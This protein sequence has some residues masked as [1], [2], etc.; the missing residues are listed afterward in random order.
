M[1]SDLDAPRPEHRRI[2]TGRPS[3]LALTPVPLGLPAT[4]SF[5]VIET[6]PNR[7]RSAS[8][9]ET[10]RGAGSHTP[11]SNQ[12]DSPGPS[13]S[14]DEALHRFF[15]RRINARSID[16]GLIETPKRFWMALVTF[17][18]AGESERHCAT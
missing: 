10:L 4:P 3:R 14:P 6:V 18:A 13:S 16:R 7:D 9:L 11:T 17:S 5:L 1:R 8:G 15:F 2:H 12:S